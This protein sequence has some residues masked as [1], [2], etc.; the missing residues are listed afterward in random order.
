VLVTI[1]SIDGAS[2]CPTFSSSVIFFSVSCTH[3]SAA[4]SSGGFAGACGAATRYTTS[5]SATSAV[6]RRA[7]AAGRVSIISRLG[8]ERVELITIM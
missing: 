1:A 4:L 3:F 8:G 5:G 6:S 2:S 7:N